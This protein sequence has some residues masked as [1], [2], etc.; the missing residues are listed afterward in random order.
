MKAFKIYQ[1]CCDITK[2]LKVVFTNAQISE[3]RDMLQDY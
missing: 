1:S 3:L 2:K